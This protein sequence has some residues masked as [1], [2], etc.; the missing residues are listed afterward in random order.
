MSR[1]ATSK[2]DGEPRRHLIWFMFYQDCSETS[3]G[4]REVLRLVR[5]LCDNLVNLAGGLHHLLR[6][7]QSLGMFGR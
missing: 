5:R 1:T 2:C 4:R 6:S 7:G 3:V